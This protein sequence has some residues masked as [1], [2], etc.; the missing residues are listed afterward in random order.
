[1]SE[2]LTMPKRTQLL[3][4]MTD[5]LYN[6]KG[7]RGMADAFFFVED[8]LYQAVLLAE[9]RWRTPSGKQRS[10]RVSRS[11]AGHSARGLA[12]WLRQ[13]GWEPPKGLAR[14]CESAPRS[15]L[16]YAR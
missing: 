16:R 10:K 4:P 3:N 8:G 7:E 6:E 11:F 1:M 15:R 13:N 5:D 12:A 14:L 2:R 9:K